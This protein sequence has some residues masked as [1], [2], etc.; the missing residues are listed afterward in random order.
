LR[1]ELLSIEWRENSVSA[2]NFGMCG[3]FGH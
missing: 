1:R 2:G 3:G